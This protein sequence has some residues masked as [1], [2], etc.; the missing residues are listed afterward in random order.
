[1]GLLATICVF[2]FLVCVAMVVSLVAY[3]Q[4]RRK[5]YG[6]VGA[7]IVVI[8]GAGV[9]VATLSA[10][11]TLAFPPSVV[12]TL[13]VAG[14][15]L[16]MLAA[17]RFLPRRH[18]RIFGRRSG[19]A[20]VVAGW[21]FVGMG[22]P[23][24]GLVLNA[25]WPAATTVTSV[26]KGLLEAVLL[27]LIVAAPGVL[28]IWRG[29]YAERQ[30]TLEH[31]LASDGRAPVIY[32]RAFERERE[33]FVWG[34]KHRYERYKIGFVRSRQLKVGIS[35]EEY[36]ATGIGKHVGPFVALGS[37]QDF[38]SPFGAARTYAKDATWKE[39]FKRL[40]K[41][42]AAILAEAEGT[43]H[44]RWE[45]ELIRRENLHTRLCIVTRHFTSPMAGRLWRQ[46]Q[47]VRGL[48]E[49]PW[50]E[51]S[52]ALAPLGYVLGEYPGPG[53][54]MSFDVEGR[55]I[56]LALGVDLPWDYISAIRAHVTTL[57]SVVER[58]V[59]A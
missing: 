11:I 31:L 7:L 2:A 42:S 13:P 10:A 15:I 32:M 18:T 40:V 48:G 16:A 36:L 28:L 39:E 49:T 14:G 29:R 47:Q 58:P 33:A 26:F 24:A 21:A 56:V 55:A 19:R 3:S 57:G 45:F 25:R 38:L 9:F 51:F 50:A 46:I 43:D 59:S 23:V 8:G 54:V 37:P 27:G 53:S 6:P 22:I 1:M 4:A 44:V 17:T 34:D 5:G 52:A 20:L 12:I 35:L 30:P 41:T